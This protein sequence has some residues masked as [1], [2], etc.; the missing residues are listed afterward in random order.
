MSRAVDERGR[1]LDVVDLEVVGTEAKMLEF[2][3]NDGSTLRVRF[4]VRRVWRATS[5]YNDL[6]EPVYGVE[7][8]LD[9]SMRDIP[10]EF[11]VSP[12]K[13]AAKRGATGQEVR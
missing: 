10:T 5:E 4:T 2:P 6:G 8:G 1:V 13:M 3:L 7:S 9:R 11:L 12:K